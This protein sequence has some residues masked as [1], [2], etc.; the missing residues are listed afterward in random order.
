MML[1]VDPANRAIGAACTLTVGGVPT[2][3]PYHVPRVGYSVDK[4]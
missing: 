2:P 3:G 1:G 4:T